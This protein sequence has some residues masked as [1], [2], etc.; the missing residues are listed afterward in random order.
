[1]ALLQAVNILHQRRPVVVGFGPEKDKI[2]INAFINVVEGTVA[3]R[4]QLLG[5]GDRED[6]AG[7]RRAGQYHTGATAGALPQQRDGTGGLQGGGHQIA[8]GK[9]IAGNQAVQVILPAG[10]GIF[11]AAIALPVQVDVGIIACDRFRTRQGI[12]KREDCFSVQPADDKH[13]RVS[14]AASVHGQDRAQCF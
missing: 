7:S 13:C 10:N 3:Y 12:P 14:S 8:A 6:R 2:R 4:R 5:A 9:G 1:M 11:R